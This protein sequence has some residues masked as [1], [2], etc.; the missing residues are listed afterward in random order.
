VRYRT[1]VKWNGR[2]PGAWFFAEAKD[3]AEAETIVNF[4][5]HRDYNPEGT[6]LST[7]PDPGNHSFPVEAYFL[8]GAVVRSTSWS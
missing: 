7:E 6:S 2:E 4:L 8:D 3:V 1:T 5:L